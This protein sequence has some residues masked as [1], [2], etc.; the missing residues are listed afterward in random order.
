MI[1]SVPPHWWLRAAAKSRPMVFLRTTQPPC[2]MLPELP[3]HPPRQLQ[4]QHLRRREVRA[5]PPV[6]QG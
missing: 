1:G 5:M 3:G 6:A 2:G 4:R